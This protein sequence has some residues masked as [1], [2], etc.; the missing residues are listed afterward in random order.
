[1]TPSTAGRG[2]KP[3]PDLFKSTVIV[4]PS[5]N[6]RPT[7]PP[8]RSTTAPP[9]RRRPAPETFAGRGA[10]R[11]AR[12]KFFYGKFGLGVVALLL[13]VLLGLFALALLLN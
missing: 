6:P 13:L 9:E 3:S 5:Q 4:P 1:M 2:D 12:R 10:G 7:P 11:G 8:Q